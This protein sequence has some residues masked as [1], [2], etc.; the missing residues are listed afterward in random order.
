MSDAP[1]LSH[2]AQP[3]R[4]IIS[5]SKRRLVEH[6]K[7][8]ADITMRALAATAPYEGMLSF[9][10]L[11]LMRF[12]DDGAPP[13]AVAEAEALD[14]NSPDDQTLPPRSD[15][16]ASDDS[17][18]RRPELLLISTSIRPESVSR[19][20]ICRIADECRGMGARVHV[21]DLRTFPPVF[22]HGRDLNGYPPQYRSLA[23]A[24]ERADGVVVGIPVYNASPGSTAVNLFQ[25]LGDKFAKK[26]VAIVSAGGSPR[27]FFSVAPLLEWLLFTQRAAVFPGTV[28]DT[29][30]VS[31]AEIGVRAHDF[32][33]AFVEHATTSH[34][35]AYL[36]PR[37]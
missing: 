36:A 4:G 10:T 5:R 16:G 35:G 17:L 31:R 22:C 18:G 23:A 26:P 13:I 3:G 37:P 2:A 20:L 27:G 24:I 7:T 28:V 30:E 1:T 33:A 12:D 29:P 15:D 9:D 6:A 11:A 32:A 34:W 14:P 25:V 8:A 19:S 21:Q